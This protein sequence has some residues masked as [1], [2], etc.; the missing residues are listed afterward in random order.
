[1]SVMDMTSFREWY[2]K[3]WN[4]MRQ[5]GTIAWARLSV[6]VNSILVVLVATDLSGLPAFSK[7]PEWLI[8]WNII[9]GVLTELIRRQGNTVQT[10]D[11]YVPELN[12][13]VEVTR[14]VPDP[15]PPPPPQG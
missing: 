6:L 9:N 7:H 13:S 11:T 5:S 14:L 3:F 4:W 10:F 1:M 12:K 15:L 2:I 8:Y